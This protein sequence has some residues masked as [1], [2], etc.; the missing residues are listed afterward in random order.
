MNTC[1]SNKQFTGNN[2]GSSNIVQNCSKLL[3]NASYDELVDNK[4]IEGVVFKESEFSSTNKIV[5]INKIIVTQDKN[6]DF[7][8]CIMNARMISAS[9]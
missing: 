1:I 7:Y 5:G 2:L 9:K 6:R 4:Q 3:D 8:Y